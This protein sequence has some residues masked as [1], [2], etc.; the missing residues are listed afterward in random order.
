MATFIALLRR[1]LSAFLFSMTGWVL[2]A[3][4]LLLSGLSFTVVLEALNR[5]PT[6]MPVTELFYQTQFFWLIVLM[7][8]PVITMRTFALEKDQ[9][10]YE[11]LMTT[12]IRDSQ[13][14]LAK[15]FACFVFYLLLWIPLLAY[16]FIV[17][18]FSGESVPLE[19]GT[20]SSTFAGIALFGMLYIAIGCFASSLTRSQVVAAMIAF[21][22]GLILFLLSF[23]SF[24]LP[25]PGPRQAML[26]SQ[27]SMVEHMRDFFRGVIDTRHICFYLTLATLF[28]FLNLKAVESRRWR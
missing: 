3:A 6:Q 1:D 18:R 5:E 13:V 26:L 10:T 15:F 4:V 14:V 27:I 20:L 11:T 2:L 24:I 25:S 7:V 8:V 21:A 28:L 12:P 23:L 19:L 22:L 17:R 16:P 9:G